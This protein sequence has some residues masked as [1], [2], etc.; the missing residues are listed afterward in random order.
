MIRV[1]T[2]IE[3]REG[4]FYELAY[5][6]E[7][8]IYKDEDAFINRH[9]EICYVPEVAASDYEHWTVPSTDE[10]CYSHKDLLDICNGDE[11]LCGQLFYSLEWICPETLLAEWQI[12]DVIENE[13]D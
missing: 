1:G 9:D 10:Y 7:G 11:N 12:S 4:V 2:R 13:T 5:A 8:C 6:G 3:T